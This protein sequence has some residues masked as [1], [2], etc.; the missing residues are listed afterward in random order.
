MVSDP[1]QRTL[2]VAFFGTPDFAAASLQRLLDSRHTISLVVTQPDR[3]RGRGQKVLQGPV[4][5]LALAHGIPV[6][7]PDR[8]RTPDFLERLAAA[9]ADIGVV[10]AYGRILPEVVLQTPRLGLIN[11]HASLL[12]RYRGA[13]PVHRAVIAGETTTGVTI[14]RV[15]RELDAGPMLAKAEYT[16]DPDATSDMVEDALARLGADLLVDVID[17]M[18]M[19]QVPEEHQDH[20]RAT[21]AHRITKEDGIIDWSAPATAIH[22]LVRGL[23]PW[24]HAYT[25]I[26]STRVLIRRTAVDDGGDSAAP[27]T[28]LEA[29]GERIVVAT[30]G[31]NLRLLDVQLEGRKPLGAREFLAGHRLQRGTVFSSV[32]A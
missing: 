32:P 28:L 9:S 17:R 29:A 4:K 21:Y 30:G 7:Q 11:V 20:E 18:A 25:W 13:A 3:P 16:I 2:R 27:G 5:E 26:G 23:H 24:P 12:P 22:N 10:A 19:G 6:T 31:G 15:V 1:S 8:L 14:M